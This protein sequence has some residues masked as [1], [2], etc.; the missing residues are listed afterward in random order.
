[1]KI[2]SR[3]A[4][5]IIQIDYDRVLSLSEDE[6]CFSLTQKEI[7]IILAQTDYIAWKTRWFSDSETPIDQ[8]IIDTL[9]SGLERKLM[10]GC[11]PDDGALHRFTE[12]GVYQ[13]ST[14]GG[15]TWVDDTENDPRNQAVLA[16]PIGGSG[17]N[18]KCAAADNARDQLQALRDQLIDILEA[19]PTA[20]AIIAGILA[21]LAVITGISGA[22]IGISV[23]LM[24]MAIAL[25]SLTPEEVAE[26]IDATALETFRCIIYCNVNNNGQFSYTGWQDVLADIDTNF[27]GFAHTFFA[28]IVS[29]M[30]YIG[31]S[32]ACTVGADTASDCGDCDCQC[33]HET[34]VAIGTF[35]EIGIDGTGQYIELSSELAT[36]NGLTKQWAIVGSESMCCTYGGFALV[37]GAITSGGL[38]DCSGNPVGSGT[39]SLVEFYHDSA[40]FTIKYYLG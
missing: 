4:G 22:A 16:P 9:K 34:D 26:Q 23:L 35:I 31:L 28:S 17:D 29:S 13:T 1:M 40:P 15:V 27:S 32:N 20:I 39:V 10:S 24:G 12:D 21:F 2:K 8:D 5:Q 33:V 11:C 38:L 19:T 3:I 37:S 6:C 14:D 30:G 25:I 36:H 7:A 18:I